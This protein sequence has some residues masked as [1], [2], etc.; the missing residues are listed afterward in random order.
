MCH[1]AIRPTLPGPD[2]ASGGAPSADS[3]PPAQEEHQNQDSEVS[4]ETQNTPFM[5]DPA[6]LQEETEICCGTNHQPGDPREEDQNHFSPSG[7]LVWSCSSGGTF[8]SRMQE[9][10]EEVVGESP[11]PSAPN[12][13]NQNSQAEITETDFRPNGVPQSDNGES[14]AEAPGSLSVS[15]SHDSS[16]TS[17]LNSQTDA[18]SLKG[19]IEY[20]DGTESYS[21]RPSDLDLEGPRD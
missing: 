5:P 12:A 9:M 19:N 16:N 2:Q 17:L 20:N 7:D 18:K 6:Q 21:D 1:Q 15:K 14:C 11:L 8:S 10:E 4:Q 3:D 13:A